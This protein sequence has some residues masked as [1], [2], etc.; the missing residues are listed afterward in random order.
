MS[1]LGNPLDWIWAEKYRPRLIDDV[2]L[3]ESIKNKFRSM[4]KTRE[5][6]HLLLSG[7]RGTGKTTIAL[8]MVSEMGS[9]AIVINGSLDGNIDTLRTKIQEF[10]SAMSLVGG[11][12][13]VILDEADY[14]NPNSVMPALRNFMETHSRNCGFILTCNHRNKIIPELYSRLYEVAFR[15]DKKDAPKFASKFMKR[16]ETILREEEVQ[17]DPPVLGAVILRHYPDFRKVLNELQGYSSDNGKIDSGILGSIRDV[18]IE[19]LVE[20]LKKKNYTEVRKWVSANADDEAGV[21]RKLYDSAT[22]LVDSASIPVLV[23]VLGKYQHYSAFSVDPEVNLSA[24]LAE[25]MVE[26]TWK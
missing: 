26:V 8:A 9:D 25:I 3:P 5:V 15:V 14:L 2:I 22:E 18:S 19:D 6:P 11:R 7:H 17:Y 1:D 20:N 21:Y 10:A 12:K 13:F 16:V 23:L 24:A 4:V